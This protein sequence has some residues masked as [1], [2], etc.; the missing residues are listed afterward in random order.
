MLKSETT[1]KLPP[2]I[3]NAVLPIIEREIPKDEYTVRERIR[4]VDSASSGMGGG[5]SE[6]I[7]TVAQASPVCLAIAAIIRQWIKTKSSKKFKIHTK[8]TTIEGENMT[9]KDITEIFS[10]YNE[11]IFKEIKK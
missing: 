11:I 4:T 9:T 7:I 2:D 3:W 10:K 8:D 1:I 6:I 5:V